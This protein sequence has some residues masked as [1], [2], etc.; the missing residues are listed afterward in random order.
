MH[1][2]LCAASSPGQAQNFQIVSYAAAGDARVDPADPHS[3]A[4]NAVR[5][6]FRPFTPA[7]VGFDQTTAA[8]DA[9]DRTCEV[10]VFGFATALVA[11][12][13][14]D[15]TA[16]ISASCPVLPPGFVPHAHLS[17]STNITARWHDTAIISTGQPGRTVHAAA[18]L[19]VSGSVGADASGQAT[20]HSSGR[21]DLSLETGDS[22]ISTLPDPPYDANWF[23]QANDDD[24]HLLRYE[25]PAPAVIPITLNL[26]DGQ[27]ATLDYMLTLTPTGDAGISD[28]TVGGTAAVSLS[29]NFSGTALWGGISSVTDA[30]TNQP[31][32]NWTISSASGFD[33]SRPAPEP[34]SAAAL[35]LVAAARITMRPVKNL[36]GA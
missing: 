32:Q 11:Q 20:G 34:A 9:S 33:Y 5:S 13:R 6:S 35:V 14:L 36:E 27:P 3:F 12:L 2:L 29:G 30:N 1:L 7:E 17:Q 26:T 28:S 25:H 21:I 16:S 15:I 22:S 4:T 10:H 31:I 19:I 24:L 8:Q 23:A 18:R